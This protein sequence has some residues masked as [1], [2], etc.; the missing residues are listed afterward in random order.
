MYQSQTNHWDYLSSG[1]REKILTPF[2]NKCTTDLFFSLLAPEVLS[3]KII[4]AGCGNGYFLQ[5]LLSRKPLEYKPVCLDLSHKMLT[6]ATSVLGN[7]ACMIRAEL[8]ALPFL[9]SSFDR[10]F[11][12][13]SILSDKRSTREETFKELYRILT[14][15]G[16]LILL[17]PAL[18]SYWEQL[19]IIR[20]RFVEDGLDEQQAIWS[21]YDLINERFFDPI[22]G[23]VNISGSSLRI[24]LYTHS[25]IEII[26]QKTGFSRFEI[27]KYAY[28]YELC[29]EAGLTCSKNGL[30]DW[31]VI[32]QK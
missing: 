16:K 19:H 10:A 7:S 17:L 5:E 18:E 13:N 1:Y 12:I 27:K 29:T 2:A 23:Y 24:K 4:D 3:G 31:F 28:P 20:E 22:G 8:N 15:Q 25:E 6:S 32:A 9:D 30:F 21:V 14:A 11:A 26:L